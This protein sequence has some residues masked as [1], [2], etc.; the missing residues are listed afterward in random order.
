LLRAKIEND[1][2]IADL[3]RPKSYENTQR[4]RLLEATK[5]AT[6]AEKT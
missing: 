5:T 2:L 3:G 1:Q 4:L 6:V